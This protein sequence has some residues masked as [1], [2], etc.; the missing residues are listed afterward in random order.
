MEITNATH[1]RTG[2]LG[3]VGKD[4]LVMCELLLGS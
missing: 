1:D 3:Q 4:V 2:Y